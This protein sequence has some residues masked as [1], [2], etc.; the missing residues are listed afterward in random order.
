MFLL[1][2][3]YCKSSRNL[4][5]IRG[6]CSTPSCRCCLDFLNSHSGR[7][8]PARR[9]VS[10]ASE[11]AAP[12]GEGPK[13]CGPARPPCGA[14]ELG[15]P[16]SLAAGIGGGV[17]AFGATPRAWLRLRRLSVY[18]ARHYQLNP[19]FASRPTLGPGRRSGLSGV[20]RRRVCAR[21]AAG[22]RRAVPC[23]MRI[24]SAECANRATK[25]SRDC[26]RRWCIPSSCRPCR[27]GSSSCRP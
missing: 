11:Q 7:C 6:R 14:S 17:L 12:H 18:H 9:N 24:P 16:P 22:C 2:R 1:P 3:R 26:T 5:T 4:K 27:T 25:P 10:G 15:Q 13:P 19:R 8:G 23:R 20:T 21:H